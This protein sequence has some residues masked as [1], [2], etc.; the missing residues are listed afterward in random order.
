MLL[1]LVP[2]LWPHRYIKP[3]KGPQARY[4]VLLFVPTLQ[5][6]VHV[7]LTRRHASSFA[8]RE[9]REVV[10]SGSIGHL[11][12]VV[13]CILRA[14]PKRLAAFRSEEESSNLVRLVALIGGPRS[15]FHTL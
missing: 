4:N 9:M 5:E 1:Y 12:V 10:Q 7:S 2:I 13:L 11:A 15:R 8:A 6:Y 14:N 3:Y